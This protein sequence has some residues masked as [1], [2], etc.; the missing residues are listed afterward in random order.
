MRNEPD[1][2]QIIIRE[3]SYQFPAKKKSICVKR[4]KTKINSIGKNSEINAKINFI[5]NI[6]CVSLAYCLIKL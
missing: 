2:N 4:D 3:N 1:K 6:P 5:I